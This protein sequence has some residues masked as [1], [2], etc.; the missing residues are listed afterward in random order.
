M[1]FVILNEEE[2]VR[3][4]VIAKDSF[5]FNSKTELEDKE[6]QEARDN[7]KTHLFKTVPSEKTFVSPIN[8]Y[9]YR[10][11]IEINIDKYLGD[12]NKV[13]DFRNSPTHFACTK[14]N[15]LVK[16]ALSVVYK[17]DSVLGV[18]RHLIYGLKKLEAIE[19]IFDFNGGS[20]EIDRGRRGL[21]LLTKEDYKKAREIE[22]LRI[23]LMRFKRVVREI[24]SETYLPVNYKTADYLK[25]KEGYTLLTFVLSTSSRRRLNVT[26]S[27]VKHMINECILGQ[28]EGLEI[29]N[30][31]YDTDA[32]YVHF[33][34]LCKNEDAV[35]VDDMWFNVYHY[36]LSELKN[37]NY[38][39]WL[40]RETNIGQE[41]SKISS[42]QLLHGEHFKPLI[43]SGLFKATGEK[44]A[45]LIEII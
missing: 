31:Y 2:Y 17:H 25:F 16:Q 45:G 37:F 15:S 33:N 36:C 14:L 13:D 22:K 12:R 24:D 21:V 43:E 11:E 34:I 10:K 28:R 44:R 9:P 39:M 29:V 42:Y 3:T 41:D 6:L 30:F 20:V 1:S 7:L 5:I 4:G 23:K 8:T 19:T 40:D 27:L 35:A 38:Y 18:P 32:P 26:N